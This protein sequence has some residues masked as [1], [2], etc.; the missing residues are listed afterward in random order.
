MAHLKRALE[1]GYNKWKQI[2]KG[3]ASN[4]DATS[5]THSSCLDPDLAALRTHPDYEPMLAEFQARAENEKK[6]LK[7]EVRLFVVFSIVC[8]QLKLCFFNY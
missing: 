1:L 2:Q 8:P 6:L 5:L 7:D 4:V 3:K